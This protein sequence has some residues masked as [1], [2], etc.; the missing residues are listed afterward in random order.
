MKRKQSKAASGRQEAHPERQ[1]EATANAG[2]GTTNGRGMREKRPARGPDGE[3]LLG[4]DD[5]AAVQASSSVP[6]GAP[7]SGQQGDNAPS[8]NSWVGNAEIAPSAASSTAVLAHHAGDGEHIS[9]GEGEC[10]AK[11]AQETIVSDDQIAAT[12]PS[13]ACVLTKDAAVLTST[14]RSAKWRA[15]QKHTK[16]A[17]QL[18]DLAQRE[19]ERRTEQIAVAEIQEPETDEQADVHMPADD[20]VEPEK[21]KKWN[22]GQTIRL[23]LCACHATMLSF[24]AAL[25]Q[26]PKRID[27]QV[28]SSIN[29][30]LPNDQF[31]EVIRRRAPTCPSPLRAHMSITVVFVCELFLCMLI[32]MLPNVCRCTCPHMHVGTQTSSPPRARTF[33]TIVCVRE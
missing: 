6:A 15:A 26:I 31:F 5:D 32:P 3:V 23:I 22:V 13:A 8:G 16:E 2:G 14:E 27:E 25:G 30:M 10:V 1:A 18:K 20:W 24:L 9:E 7:A 11:G 28:N 29:P 12:S 4:K 21:K 17:Q 33:I 19:S